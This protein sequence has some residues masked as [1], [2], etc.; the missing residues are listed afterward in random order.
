MRGRGSTS[1][2][3]TDR[4]VYDLCGEAFADRIPDGKRILCIIPD[5]T[6]SAPIDLMFRTVHK[7]LTPRCEK[8]DFLIASG[9]HPPMSKEAIRRRVG[10]SAAERAAEFSDAGFFNHL[11]EDPSQL[12]ELGEMSSREVEKLSGGLLSRSVAV[13]AN[14]LVLDYDV[15]LVIG[16]TFPHEVVGFSGGNK[17][18][19]PGISGREIIDL[20]HWLGALITSPVIIGRKDTP[21][22][23]MIDRAA[24]ML[25][26]ERVCASMVVKDGGLAGLYIASPEEAFGAVADLSARLHIV[27]KERAFRKVLSVAPQM[28][29]DLWT[30]AKCMYKL[31]P[32]VADGGE[33]IIYAP[34][35]ERVS[36]THGELIEQIGYHVR[37]YFTRQWDRFNEVPGGVLAHSTHLKGTGT[38]ERGVEKPRINV[39]LATGIPEETCRRINLGYV[40]PAT[41]DV[42]AWKGREDQGILCVPSAGEM[43]YR[44]APTAP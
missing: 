12:V 40:D 1:L 17:Y 5:H 39:S 28:Y 38:F 2:L 34:H 13:T 7:L 27:R 3:L 44:L 35:I 6:R 30:G 15:A 31:E 20:F 16:P 29:D 41:I 4:E 25:P 8:L 11:W 23:R 21:V 42:E 26:I 9:T 43:L 24:G 36:A 10:I 37:D 22:R 14:R 32:V 18:F 33:L 19:F